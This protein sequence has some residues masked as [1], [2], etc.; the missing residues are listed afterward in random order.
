MHLQNNGAILVESIACIENIT[1]LDVGTES[2][3]FLLWAES[4]ADLARECVA[5]TG[6]VY[7]SQFSIS[8]TAPTTRNSF[9]QG[10]Q[11]WSIVCSFVGIST[12][13]KIGC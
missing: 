4:V 2:P 11:L 10:Y 5:R 12:W 1:P 13:N 8:L 9:K 3:V 6:L 7:Q